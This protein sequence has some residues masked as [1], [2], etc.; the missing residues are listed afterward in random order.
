MKPHVFCVLLA[1]ALTNVAFAQAPT[2]FQYGIKL[3]PTTADCGIYPFSYTVG[4]E[5]SHNLEYSSYNGGL[6]FYS[7]QEGHVRGNFDGGVT[8]YGNPVDIVIGTDEDY[9]NYDHGVF[10]IWKSSKYFSGVA[11]D[12]PLFKISSPSQIATFEDVDV[13]INDG[14]LTISGSPALTQASSTSYLSGQG[15]LQTSGLST[16]LSSITP[17]TTSSWTNLYVPRGTV[18][19]GGSLA[20]G[21]ST[22]NNTYAIANGTSTSVA[23]GM[24]SFV[25]GVGV[26]ASSNYARASGLNSSAQ[27]PYATADGETAVARGFYSFANGLQ[28]TANSVTETVFGQYNQETP[29]IGPITWNGMDGLFRVGNGVSTTSRTDALTVLKNGQTTLTNREWKIAVAADTTKA[30]DDPASTTDSGGNALVVD[31]HTVLNGKVT[32]AKPQGDISMGVYE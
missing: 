26:T 29:F 5:T 25:N 12:K 22:A 4:G 9:P 10:N 21:A 15:F 16:A 30:L 8:T 1:A 28:V 6:V 17:P 3:G 11:T 31:G 18:S 2:N 7:N 20:L 13:V 24:Y 19:N 27:A 14:T 32:L 23:S